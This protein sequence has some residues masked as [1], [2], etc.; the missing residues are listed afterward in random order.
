MSE[1]FTSHLNRALDAAGIELRLGQNAL[2]VSTETVAQIQGAID[3]AEKIRTVAPAALRTVHHFS[4]TGG[5]LFAKCIASLPNSLLMN[6]IN[7]HSS[8]PTSREGRAKFTPSDIV[9]LLR[10]GNRNIDPELI[11]KLL[12]QDLKTI[13]DELH[14][15]GRTLILRDH[16]HSAFLVGKAARPEQALYPQVHGSFEMY[17]LVTV[18]NPVDSYLAMRKRGWHLQMMPNSF[19]E[20]CQRYHSFLDV[21]EG[22]PIVKY[23]DFVR[24]PKTTMRKICQRL[25]LTYFADFTDVFGSFHFSG[26]SGRGGRKITRRNRISNGSAEPLD[27]GESYR[28]LANRLAYETD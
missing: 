22:V 10:Q 21:H 8:I 28:E 5:T 6:E 15:I 19:E 7:M 16:A 1:S 17:S 23:E 3:R 13:R 25:S 27:G 2:S 20:Y 18:R 12:V 9:S 24:A 4:C 14:K 11:S 26:D